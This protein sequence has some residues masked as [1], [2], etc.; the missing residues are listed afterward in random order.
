[1][2]SFMVPVFL[3]HSTCHHGLLCLLTQLSILCKD[4]TTPQLPGRHTPAPPSNDAFRLQSLG[5]TRSCDFFPCR[6]T[7]LRHLAPHGRAATTTHDS[8]HKAASLV[9]FPFK[10]VS[11]L[12]MARTHSNVWPLKASLR[13]RVSGSL[14]PLV[15][16]GQEGLSC[17]THSVGRYLITLGGRCPPACQPQPAPVH[18]C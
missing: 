1:M 7:A 15:P 11:L 9:F 4:A 16:A 5:S 10:R 13:S 6:S 17:T 14:G 2:T 18:T 12:S 8:H 3:L